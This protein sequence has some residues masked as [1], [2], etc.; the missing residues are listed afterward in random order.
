RQGIARSGCAVFNLDW[1]AQ[2]ASLHSSAACRRNRF[3]VAHAS[4][5]LAIASSRSRTFAGKDCFA[6]TPKPTRETRAL[7]RNFIG[8]WKAVARASHIDTLAI[9][10]CRSEST[11][12]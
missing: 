6:E 2:A 1:G 8:D 7:P 9:C 3:W 10:R 4:R 12:T 11:K 5:V